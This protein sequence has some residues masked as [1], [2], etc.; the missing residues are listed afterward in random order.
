MKDLE[1]NGT[2]VELTLDK[3]L[4]ISDVIVSLSKHLNGEDVKVEDCIYKGK[5]KYHKKIN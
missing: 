2:E 3:K 1:V 4:D 5:K